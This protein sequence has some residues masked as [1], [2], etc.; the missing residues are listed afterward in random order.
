MPPKP[1][2]TDLPTHAFPSASAFAT[3]LAAHHTTAPGLYLKLAKKSSGHA[4]VSGAEAVETALCYGWIDGRAN[5]LDADWWLVRYTPRRPKSIWS[6]KNVATVARLV[7]EE[8]MRPAGLAAVEAAK[9]DGRWERAYAGPATMEVPDDFREA[10]EGCGPAKAFWEGVNRSE[11][12]SVLWR[13][14]TASVKSRAQRIE[15]L[16]QMLAVGKIPGAE[17]KA[18]EK[19]KKANGI[20]KKTT[21]TKTT[22]KKAI[23]KKQSAVPKKIKSEE[24]EGK[25]IQSRR[26]GLRR[27]P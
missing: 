12:Y 18:A 24:Q 4:S 23:E 1:A 25:T 21:K 9:A 5:A 10:L 7:E 11:R 6:Q 14:E 26:E 20:Q 2:P 22:A 17:A 13:V 27:R 19:S 16:V 8:R 15:A 3:F